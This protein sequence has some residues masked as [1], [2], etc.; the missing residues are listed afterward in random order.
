MSRVG[1]LPISLPKGVE[2]TYSNNTIQVKGPKGSLSQTVNDSGIGLS[3]DNGLLTV[4][5]E[6]DTKRHRSLH[7]LYRSLTNNMIHGVSIGYA[8]EMEVHGV[9][10][11]TSNQ[12]NVLEIQV[13]FSHPIFF[14]LPKEVAVET[15]TE[16][17][18]QPKIILSSIDKQLIGQVAAKIRSYKMPEPYKG[19]GI[20][21][22]G[23]EIR[24][25]A[26]KASGKK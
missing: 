15:K 21:F 9:G 13:G 6:S 8:L 14:A 4:T 19:K 1:K 20:R 10:F 18:Q 17:G 12:G 25:K 7:G 3:V 5:R 24:R 16:K 23:E 11:R 2:V 22:T 26:G